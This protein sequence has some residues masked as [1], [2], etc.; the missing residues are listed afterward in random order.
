MN[1]G[2]II[3]ELEDYVFKLLKFR[4]STLLPDSYIIRGTST[5]LNSD[6]LPFAE[7]IHIL[8]D[9]N[10]FTMTQICKFS[11]KIKNPVSISSVFRDDLDGNEI[12]DC[13]H[14]YNRITSTDYSMNRI[15]QST[16]ENI[17]SSKPG[18]VS[19]L[20]PFS[21]ID[22]REFF[23]HSQ[24]SYL[25]D[26][27]MCLRLDLMSGIRM[28]YSFSG[29][30]RS[31][32]SITQLLSLAKNGRLTPEDILAFCTPDN[33][34]YLVTSKPF[35][36]DDV[37]DYGI[38]VIEKVLLTSRMLTKETSYPM[39]ILVVAEG[40]KINELAKIAS[41]GDEVNILLPKRLHQ[42]DLGFKEEIGRITRV[43]PPEIKVTLHD[44][45][46]LK[47]DKNYEAMQI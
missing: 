8:Y 15:A 30:D 46:K 27:S 40:F 41:L 12:I 39:N 11:E 10:Q 29:I 7:N 35:H 18:K 14:L 23:I 9:S 43:L 34:G 42:T 20:L 38:D 26:T 31:N 36:S 32:C 13:A 1:C 24:L 5:E 25:K 33:N 16:D 17:P 37:F 3:Y 22:E 21:Y 44:T 45:E 47:M 2:I 19:V 4:L 28:P 6:S